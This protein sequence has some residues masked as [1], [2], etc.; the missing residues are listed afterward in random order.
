MR[1]LLALCA[2]A[3]VAGFIRGFAGFGGPATVSLLL[4]HF[5]APASLLPKIALLD[6]Y[7]YPMLL[8]NVRREARWDISVP[9]AL[10]TVA[11][12]PLGLKTMQAMDPEWLK[13]LIGIACLGAV[14]VAMSG[15]RF[16]TVPPLWVSLC[17]AQFFGWLLGTTYIALPM[18]TY[19]LL[20]PLNAATCRATVISYSVIMMP[21]LLAL[22][23]YQG[24]ILVDDL[25]PVG[26]AGLVY[27]G[28]VG[29]GSWAFTRVSERDYRKAAQWLLLVL[30][31]TVLI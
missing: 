3:S 4:A 20:Q 26:M 1:H 10:V 29:I 23:F 17:V 21:C 7:A 12:L 14:A 31:V 8:W 27:F 22:L 18:I 30:S 6:C 25:L 9:L 15:F 16:K 19:F 2:A 5:F 13:R 24:V 11:M 28:M